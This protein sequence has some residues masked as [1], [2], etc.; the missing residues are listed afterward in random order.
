MSY[1]FIDIIKEVSSKERKIL[2]INHK[3]KMFIK[4]FSHRIWKNKGQNQGSTY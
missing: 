4:S 1:Y 3:Y 2:E